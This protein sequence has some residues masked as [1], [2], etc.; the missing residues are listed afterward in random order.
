GTARTQSSRIFGA[1]QVVFNVETEQTTRE[2]TGLRRCINDL[3]SILGLAA[4]W[5]GYDS[6]QVATTLLDV[7]V[8][9]LDLDFGYIRASGVGG[10]SPREWTRIAPLRPRRSVDEIGRALAPYLAG[11]S[12]QSTQAGLRIANPVEEGTASIAVFHLGIQ[13]SVG[14]FVAGSRRSDFPT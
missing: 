7:L 13:D 12:A 14:V 3:I 11:D 8:R 6:S 5:T 4:I 9:M 1:G 10:G 2:I